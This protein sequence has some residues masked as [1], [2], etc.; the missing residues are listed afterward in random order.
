MSFLLF[1]A[2]GDGRARTIFAFND[3]LLDFG[4][5]ELYEMSKTKVISGM[6]LKDTER[7]FRNSFFTDFN[8]NFL[9]VIGFKPKWKLE[10]GRWQN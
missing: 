7:I 8:W 3:E 9:L 10:M 2:G 4:L 1:L 6:L 5:L